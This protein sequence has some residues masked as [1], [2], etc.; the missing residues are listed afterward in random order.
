MKLTK[1]T[2]AVF[3]ACT[4]NVRALMEGHTG[5]LY[6][7]RTFGEVTYYGHCLT[8]LLEN[9]GGGNS[10]TFLHLPPAFFHIISFARVLLFWLLA[11]D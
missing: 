2:K 3:C 1:V 4:C 5:E 8:E 10:R 7:T 6:L 11:K 9:R